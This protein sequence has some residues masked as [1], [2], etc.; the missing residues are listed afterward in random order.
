[1]AHYVCTVSVSQMGSINEEL[2]NSVEISGKGNE[3]N[4]IKIND[5]NHKN[6]LY[7]KT[8][9]INEMIIQMFGHGLT[10]NTYME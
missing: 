8:K 2:L 4:N 1:M 10:F 7:V 6:G 5:H 9:H 3:S